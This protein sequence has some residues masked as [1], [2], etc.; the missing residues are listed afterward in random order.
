MPLKLVS[1]RNPMKTRLVKKRRRRVEYEI[2]RSQKRAMDSH[3]RWD[4]EVRAEAFWEN[5]I[6]LQA[7]NQESILR[8]EARANAIIDRMNLM[9]ATI[10]HE[11]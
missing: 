8:I 4:A 7:R 2:W 1:G 6:S 10:V 11:S 3:D 5:L 9:E